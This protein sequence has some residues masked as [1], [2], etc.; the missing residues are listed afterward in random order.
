MN[1]WRPISVTY[2][3]ASVATQPEK[4]IAVSPHSNARG[5]RSASHARAAQHPPAGPAE[6]QHQHADADHQAKAE[7]QRRDRRMLVLE[8]VRA[9]RISAFASCLR[10]RLAARGMPM[11]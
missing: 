6:Q 11:A 8:F 2:Q 5:N 4:L 3:P 7:E 10:I 9:L 1:G